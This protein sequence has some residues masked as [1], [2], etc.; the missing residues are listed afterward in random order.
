MWRDAIKAAL[1]QPGEDG[2][3]LKLLAE[4]LITVA[5][6]GDTTALKEIGDRLDGKPT[7]PISGPDDGPIEIIDPKAAL[8]RGIVPDT[9]GE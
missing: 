6:T 5:L 9:A 3:K 4:K 1:R 2:D 8:L 7:Q